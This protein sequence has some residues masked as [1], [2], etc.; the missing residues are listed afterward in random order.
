MSLSRSELVVQ[1]RGLGIGAGDVVMVHAS[2]R[3]IGRVDGGATGLVAAL[4]RVTGPRGTIVMNLGARDDFDWVNARPEAERP[5]LLRGAAAFDKDS[6]PADPDVGVLAEVFRRL[7]G[8]VVNDH[9]DARFGA[10][11]H[12][13]ARLLREPLPW[14]D[15]YGPGSVLDRLVAA[16]AKVGHARSEL[17]AAPDLLGFAVE[18][19]RRHLGR[20]DSEGLAH[21]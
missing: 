17:I 21:V 8:T 7:P 9:P 5:M 2:L 16:D 19:M 3:A 10:R 18:W 11:G 6:T 1:L 4:E 13:A 14:D 12:Q 15:Y 20:P